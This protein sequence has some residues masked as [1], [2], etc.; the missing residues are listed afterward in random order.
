MGNALK[1]A[2]VI[3]ALQLGSGCTRQA[4]WTGDP[5]LS[6]PEV[7]EVVT[8]IH[9]LTNR[10][11]T[12]EVDGAFPW[13]DQVTNAISA[14]TNLTER[15]ALLDELTD[16]L[17]ALDVSPLN[18][19]RQYRALRIVHDIVEH[20]VLEELQPCFSA[21]G[22]ALNDA[23][24]WYYGMHLKKLAWNRAQ[25]DRTKSRRSQEINSATLDTEAAMERKVWN[26]IH[27]GEIIYYEVG[28]GYLERLFHRDKRRMPEG[29][30]DRL[31][32]K[33][34]TFLGRPLRPL[35]QVELGVSP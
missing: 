9:D 22:S 13:Q 10:L 23:Y 7:Q 29:L 1:I 14:I 11:S 16:C 17:F 35:E 5:R 28:V 27:Y 32:M 3:F 24:E 18:Y 8:Q 6:R 20:G 34:E 33:I 19:Q 21:R 30:W 25:I 31:K 26:E 12:I 4:E 15:V 2:A